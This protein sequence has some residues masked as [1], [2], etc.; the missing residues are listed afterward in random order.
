ML[1]LALM[2]LFWNDVQFQKIQS[3]FHM[4]IHLMLMWTLKNLE[5]LMKM[6]LLMMQNDA[7]H[8]AI[9]VHN[10]NALVAAADADADDA[11][12]TVNAA[13]AA[14]AHALGHPKRPLPRTRTCQP[15]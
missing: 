4:M 13:A 6:L 10:G 9:G 7:I 11:D 8:T 15:P 3:V 14:V 2:L 1:M 12:A 5:P